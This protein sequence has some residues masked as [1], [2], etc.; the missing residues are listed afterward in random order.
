MCT[1]QLEIKCLIC[2][3]PSENFHVQAASK[4]KLV[5]LLMQCLQLVLVVR[6]EMQN[7]DSILKAYCQIKFINFIKRLFAN[8]P[9]IFHQKSNSSDC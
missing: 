2:Q 7:A 4:G 8:S 5:K 3:M 1:C 9:G 6:I